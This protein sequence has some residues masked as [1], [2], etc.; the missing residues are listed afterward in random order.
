MRVYVLLPPPVSLPLLHDRLFLPSIPHHNHF[1]IL[2]I[3]GTAGEGCAHA[4]EHTK[5]KVS[6]RVPKMSE[7]KVSAG[8]WGGGWNSQILPGE[9]RKEKKLHILTTNNTFD[10]TVQKRLIR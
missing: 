3:T 4:Q 6:T 8:I 7:T 2:V 9:V 5:V 10:V 1:F